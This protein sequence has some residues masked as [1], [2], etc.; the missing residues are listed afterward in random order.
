MKY[1][2]TIMLFVLFSC[3]NGERKYFVVDTTNEADLL[4]LINGNLKTGS[5]LQGGVCIYKD[6]EGRTHYIQAMTYV[7][8][9]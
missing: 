3:G 4:K 8:Y 2:I 5:E 1:L 7:R 9:D 6:E